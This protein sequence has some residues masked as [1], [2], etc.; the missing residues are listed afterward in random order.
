[1]SRKKDYNYYDAFYRLSE[2][3]Y[4]AAAHN[5]E[6][7]KNFPPKDMAARLD[8][9]HEIEHEGD[10][11]RHDIMTNLAKEFLPPIDLEDITELSGLLDDVVD[12]LED[13]LL[14][15]FSFNV[16]AIKSEAAEFTV[17]ILKS[18]T[19]MRALM[20]EFKNFKKSSELKKLIIEI[21]QYENDG[22]K[23]YV[24]AMNKLF[25]EETDAIEVIKWTRMYDD[26]EECCDTFE[27]V[28]DAVEN[29][30]MKNT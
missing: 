22:D 28:A 27:Q 8:E 9:M 1:M 19:A 17:I 6:T 24:E 25:S 18:A 2:T 14:T 23:L 13:I 26:L 4:K 7:I 20:K 21:N 16:S 11:I 15:L 29:I 3:A 12:Y 30:V 10:E 5:H